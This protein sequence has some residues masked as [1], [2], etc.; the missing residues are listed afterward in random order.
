[1]VRHITSIIG[2]LL[3]ACS[4]Q[5]QNIVG[6]EYWFDQNHAARTYVAV[7]PSVTVNLQ[8]AQLNTNSLSLGHHQACM[9]WKDQPAVGQARWS[10]VVCRMLQVGQPGPWEIVAVRYWVGS[11]ANDS[12]PL[13]RYKY[14]DTPQTALTYNGLLDLCGFPTNP[15]QQTLKLQLLDNHG[16][17]SSV[18]TRSVTINAAGTLGMPTVTASSTTFCPGDVVTFT[19][20]PQTG[21]GFATP[22]GFN[23]QIPTTPGWGAVPSN[24]N[25]ITVTIGEI[26]GSVQAIATNLLRPGLTS[27]LPSE[28]AD[29]PR[30]ASIHQ[31]LQ[32]CIGSTVLWHA[33]SAGHQLCV[34]DRR[35]W[36]DSESPEASIETV[37]GSADATISVTPTNS[38]GD[39]GPA[40]VEQITVT[41]PSNAGANGNLIICSDGDTVNLFNSLQGSPQAGGVWRLNGILVSS[42]YNPCDQQPRRVH[43][44]RERFRALPGC[45]SQC[46]GHRTTSAQRGLRCGYHGV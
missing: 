46:R 8:N 35:G 15:P 38:C 6:Y 7:E 37:I 42:T 32:A 40:R 23:W 14:F 43:L 39:S 45:H 31:P 3:L 19:A 36:S 2:A 41:A 26:G 20:T 28:R 24:S 30:S 21:T 12:D 18:V 13:I 29:L 11:P 10:S 25:T 5:A 44:H 34:G 9:R 22:T 33:P 27:D 4:A 17:W 16:Q 1:M